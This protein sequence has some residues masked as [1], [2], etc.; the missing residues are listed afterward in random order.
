MRLGALN[1]VIGPS[2][3]GKSS[4]VFGT[5]LPALTGAPG[6]PYERL[7]GAIAGKVRTLDARPPGRTPRS[8]PATYSG[9]WDLVR[10]RFART[11]S[12]KARGMKA[13]HFS[14]NNKEGRCPACEGLGV[15][16]QVDVGAKAT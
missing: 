5:L 11:E 3:A 15:Q 7:D 10:A 4:L 14:Y 13:G 16:H 2:G 9:I 6:G 8:T 12:A 1:V